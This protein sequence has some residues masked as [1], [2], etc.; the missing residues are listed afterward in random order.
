MTTALRPLFGVILAAFIA[1]SLITTTVDALASTPTQNG[2]PALL[3]PGFFNSSHNRP[4]PIGRLGVT[5][6]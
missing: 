6:E 3:D 5:W 1:L 4:R 2:G